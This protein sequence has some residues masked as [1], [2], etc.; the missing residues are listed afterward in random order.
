MESPLA[1]QG[2]ENESFHPLEKGLTI[3]VETYSV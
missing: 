3:F 1:K 2:K